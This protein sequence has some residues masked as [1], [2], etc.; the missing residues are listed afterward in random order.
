M[1][2]EPS[3]IAAASA[4][5]SLLEA[6]RIK[7][8]ADITKHNEKGSIESIL[9]YGDKILLG[10]STGTLLVY[11]VTVNETES[12]AG[13]TLTKTYKAFTGST[14]PLE[15]LGLLRDAG[16]LIV[17]SEGIV[18]VFD[19]DTY[20]L[21]EKL[22][23]TKGATTFT[24][25]SGIKQQLQPDVEAS[26]IM[27]SRLLVACKTRLVCYEWKD[28]EFTE[29]K[30]LH[31]PDRI[32]T[33]TFVD[34]DKAICGLAS[35]YCVVDV[36]TSTISNIVLPGSHD[37]SFTSLGMSYIGIGGRQPTPHAVKLPNH[38]ALLVKDVNSQ[39]IDEHAQLIDKP[40]IAWPATPLGFGYSYPYLLCILPKLV[41]V[42]NPDTFTVLQTIPIA[43]AK[44]ITDG[45]LTYIATNTRV[46]R[47]ISTD[48]R[49]Q[50][51][52]LSEKEHKYAEAIS[53]LSLID[54]AYIENKDDLLRELKIQRAIQMFQAKSYKHALQLFSDISAPPETVIG[55]YPAH[56]SGTPEELL[57][58]L[59]KDQSRRSSVSSR[60]LGSPLKRSGTDDPASDG[61][62]TP[63][64]ISISSGMS[65]RDFTLAMR[66]LLNFLADTRRK[67]SL[68]ASSKE[69][70]EYQGGILTKEVYGNLDQA[71]ELVDTTLFKC[72]IIQSPA[73]V[74]PLLR[75]QN[76]CD[77]KTVNT[78]LSKIG[79][80]RELVDF[81]FAKQLHR[82]ALE[83]LKKL[84]QKKGDNLDTSGSAYL[85]GP[86]PTVRY[87]QRLGNEHIDLIFEF[88][89]WPIKEK[90]SFGLD[91]FLEDSTESESLD[92]FKVLDY[93]Q[94]ISR[95]LTI[96]YLEHL[97]NEEGEDDTHFH[98]ALAIEYIKYLQNDK[99]QD[100]EESTAVFTKL[101]KFLKARPYH[102]RVEKV[103]SSLP[104][105]K[106][107]SK[108]LLEVKA[109]LYGKRGEHKEALRIYT[110]DI[111][112]HVKARAYCA[113]LYEDVDQETGKQAL[114]TLL[115]LYLEGTQPQ[116]PLALE[117][118]ASQGSRMPIVEIINVIPDSTA[119]RDL[120]V[121][122]TSQIR[123]LTQASH[124]A[125]LDT[126]LRKV[127][128]V[129]TQETLLIEQQRRSVSIT[130]LKTCR[131][132]FKRLG[133][134]VVSAFPDGKVI[135]YGCVSGYRK[136]LEDETAAHG[137]SAAGA[138]KKYLKMHRNLNSENTGTRI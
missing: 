43:G 26:P 110:F 133:H 59:E 21:D 113:E 82:D 107:L 65:N 32:K 73:L 125:E 135:H 101:L 99:N 30:E 76:H 104:K 138:G 71:A 50:I 16:C 61:S 77:P 22:S 35:D 124:H 25:S 74:G 69:P 126:A 37:T 29:Y 51:S 93:I 36:P 89:R 80:W 72:Y 129:K 94:G 116:L 105:T 5:V 98:T 27:V 18:S 58:S 9:A 131:V 39:F 109:V 19:L 62:V 114:Y 84:G 67:I 3:P 42:R 1:S 23:K 28:S 117:L 108:Q 20:T 118:L 122:L 97:L 103:L 112:D 106:K 2:L 79:K 14:R 119:V 136:M 48:F 40:P 45:K 41:E 128:L 121:F 57:E 123:S 60:T 8:V 12:T 34:P 86:E 70:I 13:A 53:L 33:I 31:L 38:T 96:K 6:F 81:Y 64:I 47:L 11:Q 137:M 63:P 120:T 55:L 91:L 83:L 4:P 130:S 115:T 75:L 88:A 24:I 15:K 102:Y 92:R 46:V 111:Q 66:S 7:D 87:L 132:C 78:V 90:E 56:I 95:S 134:S 68:L 44:F 10:L 17:L 85:E 49:D 127:N 52:V 54:I 100:T